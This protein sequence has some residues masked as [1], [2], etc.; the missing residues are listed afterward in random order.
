MPKTPVTPR[1]LYL[2]KGI[3]GM[4]TP[5]MRT[6]VVAF[7]QQREIAAAREA[8]RALRDCVSL[9]RATHLPVSV[10]THRAVE[11]L[12]AEI[13]SLKVALLRRNPPDQLELPMDLPSTKDGEQKASHR[14]D[15]AS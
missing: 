2:P 15:V 1:W 9:K 7:V 13:A 6:E 4:D 3:P 14:G 11:L 5:T 10:E 8:V 12:E